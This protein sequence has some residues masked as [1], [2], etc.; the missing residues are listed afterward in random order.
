M[1]IE[2]SALHPS[3]CDGLMTCVLIT[4]SILHKKL[5][6]KYQRA[7][8]TSQYG[9]SPLSRTLVTTIYHVYVVSFCFCRHLTASKTY[10]RHPGVIWSLKQFRF[11]TISS[12]WHELLNI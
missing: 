1:P 12:F 11:D 10:Y 5:I 8:T 9:L 4:I 2:K 6:E 3:N 7:Q